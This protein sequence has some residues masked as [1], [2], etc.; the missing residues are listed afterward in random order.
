MPALAPYLPPKDA[1]FDNWFNNFQTL[2]AAAPATYGLMAGDATNITASYTT[3]HTDYLVCTSPSTK[4][5]QAVADKNTALINSKALIRPYA[6]QISNNPAV[7]SGNKIALG[8]NPK[9]STP[10]PIAIPV[11]SPTLSFLSFLHGSVNF[12]Y[13]DSSASP[14]SKAKP[15]GVRSLQLFG[16][17]SAT[18]I[19]DPTQLPFLGVYTKSPL[20]WLA[21]SGTSGQLWYWAARWAIQTGETGPFGTIVSGNLV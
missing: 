3:W 15:Y 19:T 17:M 11:T 4:T 10:T 12:A 9:T 18:P 7:T 8:L 14:T 16:K 13:R 1:D 5:K 20:Q 2:I 21:P 6:Q